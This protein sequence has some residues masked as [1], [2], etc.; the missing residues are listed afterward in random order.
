MMEGQRIGVENTKVLAR[1]CRRISLL[2]CCAMHGC[3]NR[4][5]VGKTAMEISLSITVMGNGK[6]EKI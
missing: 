6:G 2:S 4:W 5:P 1:S 3:E